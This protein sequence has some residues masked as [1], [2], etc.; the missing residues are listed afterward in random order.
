MNLF[1]FFLSS[2]PLNDEP[3]ASLDK[4]EKLSNWVQIFR[5]L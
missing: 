3:S 1:D 5:F 2:K 4:G